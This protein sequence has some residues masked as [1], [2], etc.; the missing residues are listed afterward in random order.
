MAFIGGCIFGCLIGIGGLLLIW[1]IEGLPPKAEQVQLPV[2]Q[3][4][5]AL[6][7]DEPPGSAAGNPD[8]SL[9]IEG[10]EAWLEQRWEQ[11]DREE[12]ELGRNNIRSWYDICVLREW[13]A[14]YKSQGA[15]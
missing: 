8:G 6:V 1:F 11:L 9:S 7:S 13:I 10:F 3:P 5:A 12:K 2:Q 15:A 4:D 14:K